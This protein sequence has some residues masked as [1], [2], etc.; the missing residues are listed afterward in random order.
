M[1]QVVVNR[2]SFLTLW[3]TVVARRLGYK[4]DE[5]LTLGKALAGLTAETKRRRLGF[6]AADSA[7]QRS[8]P[9]WRREAQSLGWA[10]FMGRRVPTLR[11]DDGLRA[12]SEAV[13]IDPDTVRQYLESKFEGYLAQV[14]D[15]LTQLAATYQPEELAFAAMSVYME[16]RP[17]VPSG[18][19][20]GGRKG[21]LDLSAIDRLVEQRR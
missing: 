15:K 17:R 7:E 11:T 20:G 2:A 10:E 14:E 6:Y 21:A 3:A 18:T 19:A 12:M 8:Q 4:E 1:A 5:A 9:V 13:P 16:L